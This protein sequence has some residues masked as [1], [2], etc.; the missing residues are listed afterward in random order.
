M[1]AAVDRLHD[2]HNPRCRMS[3]ESLVSVSPLLSCVVRAAHS[4]LIVQM[5]A[6]DTINII[7][8]FTSLFLDHP[9][10]RLITPP[11]PKERE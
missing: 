9:A 6:L 7:F 4:R 11:C 2:A 3:E 1:V 10:H 5:L 8:M